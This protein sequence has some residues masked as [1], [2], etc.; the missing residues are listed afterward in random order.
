MVSIVCDEGYNVLGDESILCEST[1]RWNA[2]IPRCDPVTCPTLNVTHGHFA[3]GISVFGDVVTLLCDEGY[4][5]LGADTL[6]CNGSGLW[7]SSIPS[8]EQLKCP[9][10]DNVTHGHFE[11]NG[12]IG[13]YGDVLSVV[14]DVGYHIEGDATTIQCNSSGLW[15]SSVPTCDPLECPI[16]DNVTHGHYQRNGEIGLFGDVVT[17]ICDN[18]YEIEESA[19]L[20]CNSSGLWNSTLPSCEPLKCPQL[21]NVTNGYFEWKGARGVFGDVVS[22]VCEDGYEVEGDTSLL[23]NSSGLWNSTIPSCVALECPKLD[24]ITNGHFEP[25]RDINVFTDNVTLVCDTGYHISGNSVLSCNSSGLWDSAMP[26][27]QPMECPDLGNVTNGN[28]EQNVSDGVFGDVVTVMCDGGYEVE[29]EDNLMCNSSG[30]WNTSI[31]RCDPVSC[32][33]LGNITNGHFSSNQSNKVFG[34]IISVICDEG[35]VIQGTE[36]LWCN[37]SGI[38]NSSIPS[39]GPVECPGL[40]NVTHGHFVQNKTISVYEDVVT[41][42]CEDGY[43]IDGESA[44]LC[45]SSGLWNSTISSC[46]PL[47]CPKL[48]NIKDGHFE[49]NGTVLNDSTIFFGEIVVL[50][51]DE[52]YEIEGSESLQCNSSGLWN[53]SIPSCKP[54]ECPPLTHISNGHYDRNRTN[55][56]GDKVV[57]ICDEGYEINGQS[58]IFC[59]SSG[60]WNSSI[61]S[62]DP[63]ECPSLDNITHGNF[64]QSNGF[65]NVFGDVIT[66]IC[67]A[68]YKING[69]G[70]LQCN[71][72][73]LWNS[74]IPTCEPVACPE[75]NNITNGHYEWNDTIQQSTFFGEVVTVVCDE[76][77]EVEGVETIQCNSS[78]LW[79]V[80]IPTCEPVECPHLG[81]ITNGHFKLNQSNSVYGDIVIVECDRGYEVE[82]TDVLQCNSSGLWNS[83][84]P[85]CDPLECPQ[86]PNVTNGYF[87]WIKTNVYGQVANVFGD[88]VHVICDEGYEIEGD[89]VLRCNS[90]GLW[91]ASIPSCEPLRC[92]TLDNITNGH[93]ETYG[94]QRNNSD[95]SFG[96]RTWAVCDEGYEIEG[97]E[98]LLCN[99]SGLWNST[100][101]SCEPLECPK[102]SNVSN[103]HF[104]WNGTVVDGLEHVF[105]DI[106]D[107]VCDEGY[108][109]DGDEIL[110]CNSSGLWN[111][112]IPSCEPLECP[113][114]DN[115]NH[116]YFE[117]NGTDFVYGDD[118]LVH[119]D[120]GYE[121]DGD[122]TLFCNSSGLWNS[123]IPTCDPLECSQLPDIFNGHYERNG[124]TTDGVENSFGDVVFLICDE[125]YEVEGRENVRC[126]S[127]GLW[128]TSIPTCEPLTC[129]TLGNITNGQFSSNSSMSEF[130]DI[131]SIICDAG[132]QIDGDQVLQCNSSG[133]WNDTIPSC[134]PLEC[135][136]LDNFKHGHFEWNGAVFNGSNIFFGE[137]VVL[138]CDEGYEIEGS[139]SLQCNS[140]GSWNSSIPSCEP[141]ECPRLGDIH[142]GQ[143]TTVNSSINAYNDIVTIICDQGYEVDGDVS[144]QCNSSG[145]WNTTFPTCDPLI[146]PQLNNISNGHYEP[147]GSVTVFGDVVTVVCDTGYQLDGV[148]EIRC[149]SSGLWNVSTP[150]CEPL[151]CQLPNIANGQFIS[152]GTIFND[153]N[154]YFGE[155]VTIDCDEGYNVEGNGELLCNSS[156]MWNT[157]IPSCDPKPCLDLSN[158]THG[159]FEINETGIITDGS[160][161]VYQDIVKVVCDDGY[162]IDGYDVLY[163][164]AHGMWN[165]TTQPTCDP[166]QCPTLPNVTNGYFDQNGTIHTFGDQILL[167][168]DPGYEI[169][170][171]AVISCNASGEWNTS[172]PSCQRIDC[173]LLP[174]I[175]HASVSSNASLYGDVVTVT[176]DQ[177]YSL[178]GNDTLRCGS[179]GEWDNNAPSCDLVTCP[180]LPII[181]NARVSSNNSDCGTMVTVTCDTGYLLNGSKVLKC[182]SKGQWNYTTFPTCDPLICPQLNN[183]SNG[184]YE[185][186]GSVTVFGDV[187]IAVCDTGYLLNGSKVLTCDSEGEWDQAVSSCDRV[188]CPRP[189]KL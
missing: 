17:I 180:V 139:A 109:C 133:L 88:I 172:L 169:L 117:W 92:P 5:I 145:K 64:E 163:C 121:I 7:N 111:S 51:C 41:L 177:C 10:L 34:D 144:V 93:Y 49:W 75:L 83:T 57:V 33:K 82:G 104:E 157:K 6:Q 134:E 45:N 119:C 188:E 171:N 20:Q 39:C 78:A 21:D 118:I 66:V 152:N 4:A 72:S 42:V 30:M 131:V 162:E 153:S 96:D 71:S 38:W 132:Y 158:L 106:I 181:S 9:I 31:P 137:I 147:N 55:V 128:N 143:F 124:N 183:I 68:G 185:P 59:N 178:T 80:S 77:Y 123:S 97:S 40:D 16:L 112:S 52:G 90:S 14:C 36:F 86:L 156:G 129:P 107:L 122:E 18:G 115:I 19:S 8:C 154:I 165:S 140:S 127:S 142:N 91:N 25:Y 159:H 166:V 60:L 26:S 136:R 179:D 105:G 46:D 81:N 125:G 189:G 85:T 73:G 102:L 174:H 1:G 24:N 120:E 89:E 2:T 54:L 3:G 76:G 87:E 99:S 148:E 11:Q 141:V 47:E 32:P 151:D 70:V 116:G 58:F 62:C 138:I 130:G 63:L 43:Q 79:N 12:G 175:P 135:P 98:I 48:D 65:D 149:N 164:D 146:C 27:C 126:N 168:C 35:Y 173:P 44:L 182:G 67:D 103:S 161:K 114:L 69:E 101:P 187:V 74:T 110:Y 50:K 84:M 150:S 56:F 15:N 94:I 37:S 184:H 29:G 160:N 176:C 95:H 13:A 100:F 167:I 186:N 155:I 61:P 113:K 22:V 53:V 28:F 23:C 108:Q 170:G